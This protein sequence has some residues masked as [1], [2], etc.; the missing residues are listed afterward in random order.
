[1]ALDVAL[2]DPHWLPH[3]VRAIGWMI[4]RSERWVRRSAI[5][6]RAA[7]IVLCLSVVAA[8]ATLVWLT[9]PWAN[10]YWAYSFVALR[11]LDVESSRAIRS[12]AA[13]D[14][15]GARANLAMIVG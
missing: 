2:G 12:L 6:L 14:I 15:D 11:S 7:G 3:P 1:M 5:P 9:L 10:I 4:S 8:S 13:G